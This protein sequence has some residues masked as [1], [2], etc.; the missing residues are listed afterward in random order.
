[1]TNGKENLTEFS[2]KGD[3]GHDVIRVFCNN[4]GTSVCGWCTNPYDS[5]MFNGV[6]SITIGIGTLDVPTEE[7]AKWKTGD[8]WY[9]E[10][11]VLVSVD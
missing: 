11:R 9:E 2:I 3:S 1:V 4:C 10:Q 5:A 6:G 7:V 8:K